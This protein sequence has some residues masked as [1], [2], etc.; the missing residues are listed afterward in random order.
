MD[1]LLDAASYEAGEEGWALCSVFLDEDGLNELAKLDQLIRDNHLY[2]LE[3]R[4]EELVGQFHQSESGEPEKAQLQITMNGFVQWHA[5]MLDG[6]EFRASIELDTLKRR[7]L[8]NIAQ[9]PNRVLI[10][11]DGFVEFKSTTAPDV[12]WTDSLPG[13]LRT[14][15]QPKIKAQ[16]LVDRAANFQAKTTLTSQKTL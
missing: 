16:E 11:C 2:M 10:L 14:S 15:L 4:G 7:W 1:I 3:S 6:T 9:G 8:E 5:D 12:H 13:S